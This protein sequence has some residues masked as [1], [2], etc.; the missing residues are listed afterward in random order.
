MQCAVLIT[1]ASA[2]YTRQ[3]VDA[4]FVHER[5]TPRVQEQGSRN[6]ATHDTITH[7]RPHTPQV[8]DAG[9][10]HEKFTP[11]G[12]GVRDALVVATN[13]KVF[14]LAGGDDE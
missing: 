1:P 11:G 9:F 14:T 6:T 13:H 10:V 2:I 12:R 4:G 3:V 8:V 7:K 5:F